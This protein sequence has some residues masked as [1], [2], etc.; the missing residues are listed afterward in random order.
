MKTLRF[1]R[2]DLGGARHFPLALELGEGLNVVLGPNEAGKS[3]AQRALEFLLFP[4]A[5]KDGSLRNPTL[6]GVLVSEE[7][8]LPIELRRGRLVAP[9]DH[10]LRARVGDAAD[11][12]AF[13]ALFC[14]DHAEVGKGDALLGERGAIG[15]VLLSAET[16]GTALATL[17]ESMRARLAELFSASANAK[18][19]ELNRLVREVQELEAKARQRALGG[20]YDGLREAYDARTKARKELQRER[21]RAVHERDRLARLRAQLLPLEA[22]RELGR[23]VAELRAS[24]PSVVRS[25]LAALETALRRFQKGV[26]DRDAQRAQRAELEAELEATPDL[27]SLLALDEAVRS[28]SQRL[29]THRKNTKHLREHEESVASFRASLREEL[30]AQG[31]EVQ[32]GSLTERAA[33]L[34]LGIDEAAAIRRAIDALRESGRTV[35][36]LRAELRDEETQREA[37]GLRSTSRPK[38]LDELEL[39]L[40]RHGATLLGSEGALADGRASVAR[41]RAG[42]ERALVS[43]GFEATIVPPDFVECL[44]LPDNEALRRD[45]EALAS[46]ER[47]VDAAQ[48]SLDDARRLHAVRADELATAD[49]EREGA[50][51]ADALRVLREERDDVLGRLRTE[52]SAERAAELAERIRRVDEATDRRFA[53]AKAVE[54]FERAQRDRDEAAR[55]EARAARESELAVAR[56]DRRLADWRRCVAALPRL[57]EAPGRVN[58]LLAKVDLLRDAFDAVRVADEG[59]ARSVEEIAHAENAVRDA[60]V[61]TLAERPVVGGSP[62]RELASRRKDELRRLDEEAREN[63]SALVRSEERIVRK[64]SALEDASRD[65]SAARAAFETA[66]SALPPQARGD[67]ASASRWLD[68]SGELNEAIDAIRRYEAAET[69]ARAFVEDVAALRKAF[70]DRGERVEALVDVGEDQAAEALARRMAEARG[71]AEK[72]GLLERKTGDA[73]RRE[74]EAEATLAPARVEV[75]RIAGELGAGVERLEDVLERSRRVAA[76]EEQIL[77]LDDRVRHATGLDVASV[78]AEIAER[79]DETLRMEVELADERA[80]ALD[81]RVLT[82]NAEEN[83]AQKALEALV[84]GSDEHAERIRRLRLL[85]EEL[86]R[87]TREVATKSLV[88]WAVERLE[89]KR[90]QQASEHPLLRE[91]GT[92]LSELTDGRY[93]AI[94]LEGARGETLVVRNG[95]GVI[96]PIAALSAGTRDQVYFALRLAGIVHHV[97]DVGGRGWPVILDDVLVH[98][99]DARAKAGLRALRRLAS[100]TGL[101]VILFTHH[102][103]VAEL[104]EAIAA[105]PGAASAARISIH[106]LETS[107]LLTQT[108]VVETVPVKPGTS[109]SG[110]DP[111]ALAAL[112]ERVLAYLR[113]AP[114]AIAKS[115][116]VRALKADAEGLDEA[117]LDKVLAAEKRTDENPEGR[118]VVQGKGK[119]TKY[120]IAEAAP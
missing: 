67:E 109:R 115:E 9:E 8:E 23:K 112:T 2:V 90:R 48:R 73:R 63:A 4:D 15:R 110:V 31:L 20:T 86:V 13:R 111:E 27:S 89:Q 66:A 96:L 106:R 6:A 117:L 72:R 56:R 78:E 29:A 87:K 102:A 41:A 92:L 47:E 46:E 116:L 60:L 64:R 75:D 32:A 77:A 107:P 84:G 45:A 104:A 120:G 61:A 37:L 17:H 12:G 54:R 36:R 5:P 3:T 34:R 81:A 95:E 94:E 18:N 14:L 49:R 11:R 119:G 44:G 85:Q 65:H 114:D 83:E 93:S 68:A 79:T 59:L 69:E 57:A 100:E 24:G 30:A 35:A 42:M 28:L 1:G 25:E 58:E 43:L 80:K 62:L 88:K 7:G 113:G 10:L 53:K 39:V 22:R 21:D 82:A 50:L 118:V 52:P 101:Q 108:P 51:D 26:A 97:R 16:G 33:S 71:I 74:A 76:L 40:E 98:F 70:A 103:H 105:E 55:D 99:D 19:P 91:A 38:G